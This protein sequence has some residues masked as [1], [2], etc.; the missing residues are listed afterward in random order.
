MMFYQKSRCACEEMIH[1]LQ[2]LPE[3]YGYLHLEFVRIL[4][5]LLNSSY[6]ATWIWMKLGRSDAP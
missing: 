1:V 6:I 4:P 5:C 2:I 3:V